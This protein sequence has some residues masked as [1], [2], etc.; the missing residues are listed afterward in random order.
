MLPT[1]ALLA[2]L[3]A[4]T[5]HARVAG[6]WAVAEMA[7]NGYDSPADAFQD[8][9]MT[10]ARGGLT[11]TNKADKIAA[12]R[13]QVLAVAGKV[14][15]FDLHMGDGPDA[16]KTFPGRLEW[17][18]KDTL[19]ARIIQ[20]GKERPTGVRSEPGDRSAEVLLKRRKPDPTPKGD[21]R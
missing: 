16:G 5:V 19:R 1:L 21:E 4:A 14:V 9:R 7:M 12:G 10:F 20:P 11:V 13:V 6:T 2:G 8:L 18:D 3:T 15:T 17:A